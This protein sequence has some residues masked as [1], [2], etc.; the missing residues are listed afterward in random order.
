MRRS[1]AWL[2][3]V[4]LLGIGWT[5]MPGARADGYDE[6]EIRL[7]TAGVDPAL[8]EQ[9]HQAIRRGIFALRARQS[10]DGSFAENLGYTAL[11]ALALRHTGTPDGTEASH[12]ALNWILRWHGADVLRRTYEAGITAMLLAADRSHPKVLRQIHDQLAFGPRRSGG[13]W[14][15]EPKGGTPPANL[16]TSQFAALGLWA[17]ERFDTPLARDAWDRHLETLL[18]AQNEDGSWGYY[19][20][21]APAAAQLDAYPTG[22]F[23]GLADVLLAEQALAEPLRGSPEAR[24]R[25]LVARARGEAALRRHVQWTLAVPGGAHPMGAVY[26][27]YRLFALEKACVFLGEEEVGG[28]AWYR[29]GARWLLAAQ[30]KDGLW[31][32]AGAGG[33]DVPPGA[34]VVTDTLDSSFALLFLLRAASVYRPITPRDPDGPP[35]VTPRDTTGPP[36]A[37]EEVPPPA[38]LPLASANPFLD[39]IEVQLEKPAVAALDATLDAL[40]FV[41]RTYPTYRPKGAPLSAEHDAWCLRAEELLLRGCTLHLGSTLRDRELR[42]AIALS[43]LRVLAATDR[44]VSAAL[45]ER[46]LAL[47]DTPSSPDAFQFAWCSE[48]METLRRL[49]APALEAWLATRGVAGA[50]SEWPRISAA[51]TTLGAMNDLDGAARLATAARLR[52]ALAPLQSLGTRTSTVDDCLK[53]ACVAL[54]RIV[55]PGRGSDFPSPSL[56][57]PRDELDAVFRWLDRH[58]KPDDPVWRDEPG[59]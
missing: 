14:D 6:T 26:A 51:L 10:K 37:P 53:D 36:P 28:V 44:R 32:A 16:S 18:R 43:C 59:R 2:G 25:V 47:E 17:A 8:R 5:R 9:I 12:R 54:T 15:Y 56:A 40:R 4:V 46:I 45:M 33:R 31:S 23:M 22:T 55:R 49:G 19:L 39:R 52:T 27:Y 57:V 50:A 38:A 42:R 58:G 34:I 20:P 1:A 30:A 48:A 29:D 7:K 41:E 21:G 24:A 11:A 13:Y 35:T 3:C